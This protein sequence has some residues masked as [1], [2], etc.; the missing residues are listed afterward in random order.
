MVIEYVLGIA[1][2]VM[3]LFLLIA[4]LMQSGKD[5]RLSGSIAGG[6]ET[7]F[8]KTKGKQWDKVLSRA[9]TVVSIVF[10]VTV[11]V[12]YVVISGSY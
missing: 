7:F 9:T 5:K 3:A 11:V 2:I 8:G 12:A 10:A 1:L 6:A 4:V